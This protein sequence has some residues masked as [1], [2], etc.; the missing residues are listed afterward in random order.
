MFEVVVMKAGFRDKPTRIPS[1][2]HV[3]FKLSQAAIYKCLL[4]LYEIWITFF[5]L[6]IN[7]N[8]LHDFLPPCQDDL[9]VVIFA[10]SRISTKSVL[11][12]SEN[13]LN[14]LKVKN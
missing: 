11:P 2:G 13:L 12:I 5:M 9:C 4:G 10:L 1:V 14:P 3:T 8:N 7:Q 6:F